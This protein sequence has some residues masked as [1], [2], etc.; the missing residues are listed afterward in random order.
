MSTEEGDEGV[1]SEEEP[2]GVNQ[3][4]GSPLWR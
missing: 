1:S 4:H 3:K 2:V